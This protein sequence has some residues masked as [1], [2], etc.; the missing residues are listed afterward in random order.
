[1]KELSHQL[2]ARIPR[3]LNERLRRRARA[4]RRRC[5]EI[6]RLALEA[7]LGGPE[8]RVRDRIDPLVGSLAG[9][10]PDLSTNRKHLLQ[11]FRERR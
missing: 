11:A 10:P 5:S 9:G 4:A 6:V 7:Y 8:G 2:V 1:M 3:V